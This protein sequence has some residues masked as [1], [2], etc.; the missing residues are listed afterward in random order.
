MFNPIDPIILVGD[1][2]GGV[3]SFKLIGKQLTSGPL[4]YIPPKEDDDGKEAKE[5]KHIPTS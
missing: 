4:E 1:E 2:M 3:N 5:P